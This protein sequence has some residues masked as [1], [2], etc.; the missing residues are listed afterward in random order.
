M[1]LDEN[2]QL[3]EEERALLYDLLNTICTMRTHY[4]IEKER[5][6]SYFQLVGERLETLG[7][8]YKIL[9]QLYQKK[10]AHK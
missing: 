9:E 4:A 6:Q 8:S 3:V 1:S 2:M 5:L 10:E 7:Q